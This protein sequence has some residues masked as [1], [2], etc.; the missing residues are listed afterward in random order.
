MTRSDILDTLGSIQLCTG[1]VAGAK[2]AVYAVSQCFQLDGTEAILLVDSSNVFNSLNHNTTLHNIRFMCPAISTILINTYR[3]PF[4]LFIDGK[5]I[6]S[7]EGTTQD[8]PFTMPL[9]AAATL[10]MVK[11]LPNQPH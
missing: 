1:Q 7:Q 4:E 2:S 9:Y 5:V 11:R 8:D 10:P 6:H 3:E